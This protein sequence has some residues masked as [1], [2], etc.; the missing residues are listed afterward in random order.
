MKYKSGYK[1]Q[2]LTTE[3]FNTAIR[4]KM[5]VK[6]DYISLSSDGILVVGKGY[7]WDGPSGPTIDT[8]S[9][10]RG[11]LAHDALYQFMRM[12]LLP[13]RWRI[14]ADKELIKICEKDGMGWIRRW[15]V[16]KSLKWFGKSAANPR[17][18]VEI[19][20]AP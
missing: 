13:Q 4:P 12:R 8:K 19:Q 14:P 1:Y 11:S 17:N 6:T 7:A 15:Y 18:Q 3:V 5:E 20:K 9:F 10:M 16:E 2:L